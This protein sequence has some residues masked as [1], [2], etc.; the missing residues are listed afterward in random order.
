MILQIGPRLGVDFV[1]F[2]RSFA[3]KSRGTILGFEGV[4]IAGVEIS[5]KPSERSCGAG[6]VQGSL[7][8][9][10]RHCATREIAK[11]ISTETSDRLFSP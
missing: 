6:S 9:S 8:P 1:L 3:K 5:K 11:S 4:A 2:A 7:R 10:P